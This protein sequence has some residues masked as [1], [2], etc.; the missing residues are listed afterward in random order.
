M[1]E[2]ESDVKT[3]VHRFC[4]NARAINQVLSG[5]LGLTKDSRFDTISNLSKMKDKNNEP[6]VKKIESC[7]ALIE[8]ALNFVI[9]LEN[10][11]KKKA[12]N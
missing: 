10:L 3:L 4:D 5:I 1:R 9:D 7:Q 12:K 2:L 8:S 11:D 6:F